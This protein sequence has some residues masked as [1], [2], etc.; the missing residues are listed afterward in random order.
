M[1]LNLVPQEGFEPS[2]T[3]S[4]DQRANRYTTGAN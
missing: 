1:I 2:P 3:G 4:E